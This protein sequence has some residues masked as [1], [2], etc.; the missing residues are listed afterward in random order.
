M[1]MKAEIGTVHLSGL[2]FVGKDC[3]QLSEARREAWRGILPPKTQKHLL[4]TPGFGTSASRT[5]RELISVVLS[6]PISGHL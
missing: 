3:W 6:H 4:L 1:E 2:L 5:G